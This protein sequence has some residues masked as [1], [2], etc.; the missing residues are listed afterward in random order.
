MIVKTEFKDHWLAP[1]FQE[2]MGLKND[3]PFFRIKSM[4]GP[5][6]KYFKCYVT[7]TPISHDTVLLMNLSVES[8]NEDRFG[9]STYNQNF[10]LEKYL[11][12]KEWM[13][14]FSDVPAALRTEMTDV[15]YGK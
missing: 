1:V 4:Y 14:M 9:Y 5:E 8:T 13:T 2:V 12:L 6:Q 11:N 3:N 7:Y 10:K 15:L